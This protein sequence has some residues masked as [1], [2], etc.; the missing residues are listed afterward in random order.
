[1]PVWQ[2]LTDVASYLHV[3]EEVVKNLRFPAKR[4]ISNSLY[5]ILLNDAG[6]CGQHR[7]FC[8]S[9]DFLRILRNSAGEKQTEIFPA[10]LRRIRR[11]PADNFN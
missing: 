8:A 3:V 4:T 10:E 6:S 1:M 5:L 7:F 9:A 2:L 11:K